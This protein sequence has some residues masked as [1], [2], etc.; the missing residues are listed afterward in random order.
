M[1]F[2]VVLF[3]YFEMFYYI[4]NIKIKDMLVG[5][6]L[7]QDEE[8][9]L[10]SIRSK[11]SYGREKFYENYS[12]INSEFSA[13]V[14]GAKIYILDNYKKVNDYSD[15]SMILVSGASGER[16]HLGKKR[17]DREKKPEPEPTERM[18]KFLALVKPAPVSDR[19][20]KMLDDLDS[21][22]ITVSTFD[23]AVYDWTDGDFSVTL[24]EK[25]Y[26]WITSES[27]IEIA[28]YIETK[29]KE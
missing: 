4:C 9:T 10:N 11:E 25:S 19:M 24:N 13:L 17:A 21:K 20:Q 3:F 28:H 14:A 15:L 22:M 27:V 6:D 23:E 16:V 29:L 8:N 2:F 7:S 18:K 12:R 5:I 26:L 1:D